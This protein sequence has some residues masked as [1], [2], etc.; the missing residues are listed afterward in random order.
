MVPGACGGPSAV[1][2][3][4]ADPAPGGKG[5]RQV[6]EDEVTGHEDRVLAA[7]RRLRVPPTVEEPHLHGMIEGALADGGL[8]Y[9][10]EHRLGPRERID[11]LV[12]G[13]V[14]IEVKK[15]HPNGTDL[16]RQVRRYC[17]HDEVASLV[18]VL[19]WRKHLSLP[20]EINGRRVTILCLNDL[21]GVAV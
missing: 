14:G 20:P 7:L 8:G 15:G 6:G 18:V 5:R 16:L 1:G 12:E 13:S 9:S 2:R 19:P 10:H 21:W 17:A 4:G 11:F 3:V